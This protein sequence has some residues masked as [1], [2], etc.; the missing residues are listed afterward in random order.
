MFCC[1]V[2]LFESVMCEESSGSLWKMRNMKKKALMWPPQLVKNKFSFSLHFP[3]NVVK[4][5]DV[6]HAVRRA[7]RVCD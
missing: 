7:R 6:S 3:V 4:I 1:V 5:P 2:T